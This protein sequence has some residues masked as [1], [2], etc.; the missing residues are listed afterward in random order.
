MQKI[1]DE[2]R[3]L[4]LKCYDSYGLTEDI[5]MEHAAN[6]VALFIRAAFPLNSSVTIVCGDGNNGADGLALARL[7]HGDYKVTIFYAKKPK[8]KLALLQEK[9]TRSLNIPTCEKLFACDI[10]VDALLGTGFHNTLNDNLASL[11][12]N[13][14]SLTAYKIACDIPSAYMFYA[15]TTLTMGALKK[16]LFLDAH[17][18]YVGDI[19]VVNL[20]IPRDFYEG[21][22]SWRLLDVSD[23]QLPH[24][25]KKD[26]HKGSYGHLALACGNKVGAS[27][28]SAKT[29]LKFGAGLVTLVNEKK[30]QIPQSIMHASSLPQTTTALACG[31]G[32]GEYFNLAPL[33]ENNL[34]MVVDADIFHME[35]LL[36][37]LRRENTVL[38]P[39]AKEFVALLQQ[40]KLADISVSELQKERFKYVSLFSK[41]FPHVVLL[42]KGANVIIASNEKYFI[43]PHGTSSLA[44]GG[45]GDV[46][47]GLV[48]ALLAQ[49]FTPLHSAIHASLAH[50]TLASSYNGTDFS[51]T[52]D[53]LI[54]GIGNL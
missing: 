47:S 36:D 42:L 13:M 39:H 20:G 24:R 51:L 4:D 11:I 35:I 37:I 27:I 40:T 29:A 5:L 22:S 1:F 38:T 23:L 49:G 15:D 32:L 26:S 16:S 25:T 12:K 31:M 34:P 14:N 2:V 53:D 9:R 46:L 30:E 6:G 50:T 21:D 43:N 52:P 3:S 8:S 7:L 19:H 48:G 18:E 54:A 10:L 45:S 41:A 44:K 17:K 28:M 33:L